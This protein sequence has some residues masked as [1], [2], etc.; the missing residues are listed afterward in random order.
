MERPF[1]Y[2]EVNL[3]GALQFCAC[4]PAK[5][6][7]ISIEVA[8]GWDDSTP[9]RDVLLSC[10]NGYSA[11]LYR[12]DFDKAE[13]LG[14]LLCSVAR[15]M[16]RMA[17]SIDEDSESEPDLDELSEKV[18]KESAY[19]GGLSVRARKVLRRALKDEGITS[20]SK[21]TEDRLRDIKNCGPHTVAEIRRWI[22][23]RQ[24][25]LSPTSANTEI[26][27]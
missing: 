3:V 24:T 18:I 15:G 27:S 14:L 25:E 1:G 22:V 5:A 17:Q 21:L 19:E 12:M 2:H 9:Q 8:E 16:R 26:E 7:N 4:T 10:S 23:S 13:S 11:T 20:L 6:N